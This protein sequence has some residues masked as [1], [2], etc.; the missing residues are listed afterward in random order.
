MELKSKC[1]VDLTRN[2]KQADFFIKAM[3]A[4]QGINLFKFLFYGGGIRGGKTFVVLVI[5]SRLCEIFPNSRWCIVR[6]DMPSIVS[7]TVPSFEKI[8]S[9]SDKWKWYRDKS[10]YH[11]THINGSKIFF[12]GENISI[13][14]FLN[15]FLGLEVNGFFLEQMEELSEKMLEKA[16]ERNGSWYIDNMPRGLIF[17]TFNP[18]QNWVKKRFYEPFINGTL[19][20]N[21]LFMEALPS[22]NPFVTQDQYEGWGMMAERY[23]KQFIGGSWDNFDLEDGR[24]L[25]AFHRSKHVGKTEWNQNEYTYLT[26]DF[27]R[28]PMTCGVWQFYD[29]HIY[30][31]RSIKFMD[32]TVYRMCN[33][34]LDLYPNAFFIVNGDA[35]GSNLTTVNLLD[36][37]KIIKNMLNLAK[38]Q[39]QYS[40][41][42]PKLKDSRVMCNSIF[43]IM[44]IT[45]DEV[46]CADFINDAENCKANEDNT[47][48]KD[49]RN[50]D[51]QQADFLDNTRYFLHRNFRDIFKNQG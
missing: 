27:N 20:E 11:A 17:G 15:K 44:N 28:N 10:D 29:D 5:L 8:I 18:C 36:N 39:M 43:E 12:R 42:N 6:K 25:F 50:K 38:G 31:I 45:V 33:E 21:I 48:V 26:F 19:P 16:I 24:W 9:G 40:A 14:P 34:I 37:Y 51:S 3:S 4:S 1:N 2:K 7:T 13:D 41:S 23:Q 46:N 47:I 22:D 49:N 32:S 35:S 30:G